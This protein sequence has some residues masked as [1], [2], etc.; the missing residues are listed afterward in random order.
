MN[1]LDL[2]IAHILNRLPV[3]SDAAE[4]SVETIVSRSRSIPICDHVFVS[5][6]VD[7]FATLR[8][9]K[10]LRTHALARC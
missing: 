2:H 10:D 3:T 8:T 4:V 7:A 5:I 1:S 6:Q 9:K